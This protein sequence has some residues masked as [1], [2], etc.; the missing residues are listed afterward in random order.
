MKN[1]TFLLVLIMVLSAILAVCCR[2]QNNNNKSLPAKKVNDVLTQVDVRQ[3]KIGGELG[4][5]IDLTVNG[6]LLKIDIDKD[7][8]APFVGGNYTGPDGGSEPF[9]GI[10][11]VLDGMV[12]L[13]AYTGNETLIALKNHIVVSLIKSQEKDGYIGILQPNKRTWTL[14]DLHEQAF[15]ITAFVSD[16]RFFGDQNSLVAAR[17]LADYQIK[18]WPE[19]PSD[20]EKKLP[21][22]EFMAEIGLNFSY[23]SLYSVTGDKRY[24]DFAVNELGTENWNLDIVIGRFPPIEGHSYTYLSHCLAQLELYRLTADDKLLVPTRRAVDF[25]TRK[26][27]MTITGGVGHFECW[28]DDQ[29][30][31]NDLGETCSTAYQTFVFEG[32]MRLDGDSRWGDL[33]ERMLYN[34]AFGAQSPDGRRIRYYTPFEGKKVY[35]GFDTYCCPG[36]FRRLMGLLPQMVFYRSGNGLAIS[37]YSS[38]RAT[39]DGIGGSKVNIRQETDYPNTGLIT[40]YV[41]PQKPAAFPLLLRIPLWC[42]QASVTINGKPLDVAT[43]AGEFLRINRTWQSGDKVTLDMPMQWRFVAGRKTQTGRAAVMRGPVVYT[44]NPGKDSDLTKIDLKRLV[45]LPN[46]AEL[47]QDD[48]TFRPG[49]TA[50][51]IKA[52]LDKVKKGAFSLKLTEFPDP[53]GIWTYFQIADPKSLV[54]DE[55]FVAAR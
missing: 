24:L 10:G 4:R 31:K 30:G 35:F 43:K 15:I 16:Y 45:L 14:W 8:L 22:R 34:T 39:I 28:T 1:R 49:G 12:H 17:K 11:K 44:L 32:L 53:D 46:T 33:I 47:V 55:L 29:D 50:C 26:D 6:N 7:F 41:D 36:N 38:S 52:D 21:I 19:K 48:T 18:R 2:S 9:I 27:G 3:V 42:S 37:L 13:A 20:W 5:R 25:M 51:I 40:V 23:I 54:D